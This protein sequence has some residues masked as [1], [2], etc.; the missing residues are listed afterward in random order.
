MRRL[1]IAAAALAVAAAAALVASRLLSEPASEE[2]RIRAAFEEAAR[3]AGEKRVGDAVAIVSERFRGQGLDR[4]GVK[5][6]VAYQALRGEWVSVSVAGV[7]VAVEGEA[8]RATLDLVL[9]RSGA[10]KALADLLP[11]E[12]SAW[13]IECGLEVEEGEWRVVEAS[14]R[15]VALAEALSGPAPR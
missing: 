9:A 5:Q 6:L 1:A 13:R 11:A 4:Q 7:E 14:W 2:D 8:A 15:P 12:A 10:G 3:A